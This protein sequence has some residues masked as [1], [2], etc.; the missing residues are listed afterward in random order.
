M[1]SNASRTEI[2]GIN[3]RPANLFLRVVRSFLSHI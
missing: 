3:D 1:C 2:L